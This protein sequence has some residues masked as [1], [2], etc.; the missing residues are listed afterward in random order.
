MLG[1][2][3]FISWRDSKARWTTSLGVEL[4]YAVLTVIEFSYE[5]APIK[6]CTYLSLRISVLIKDIFCIASMI[7]CGNYGHD[8]WIV[9]MTERFRGWE[10][11]KTATLKGMVE[12]RRIKFL[13]KLLV[14]DGATVIVQTYVNN[15]AFS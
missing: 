1:G 13:D 3:E 15:L 6:L 2:S 12:G 10:K 5:A 9:L 11:W 4:Q 14:C 7:S 8:C